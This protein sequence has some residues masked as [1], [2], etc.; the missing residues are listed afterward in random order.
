MLAK[1]DCGNVCSVL[2]EKLVQ[3]AFDLAR[4]SQNLLQGEA[5]SNFIKRSYE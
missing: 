1:S 5:L 2:K 4:L 3:Q